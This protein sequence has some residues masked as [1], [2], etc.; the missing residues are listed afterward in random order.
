[1]QSQNKYPPFFS[2]LQTITLVLS[3]TD[4]EYVDSSGMSSG[5]TPE[6]AEEGFPV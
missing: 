1:M 6:G 3:Q 2:F 4:I 5:L